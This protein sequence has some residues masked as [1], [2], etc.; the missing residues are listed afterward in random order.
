MAR[1]DENEGV[2]DML[3]ELR[4]WRDDRELDRDDQRLVRN[5]LLTAEKRER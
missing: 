4:A 1:L 2:R 5:L 3:P